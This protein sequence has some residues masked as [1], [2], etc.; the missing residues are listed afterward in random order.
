MTTHILCRRITNPTRQQ[1][2]SPCE[3]T[4]FTFNL[5]FL[6]LFIL[7]FE[8]NI[9]SLQIE[10]HNTARSSKHLNTYSASSLV[11]WQAFTWPCWFWRPYPPSKAGVLGWRRACCRIKWRAKSA[12]TS[13]KWTCWDASSWTMWNYTTAETPWCSK[14]LESLRKSIWCP[15]S[16]RKS[17]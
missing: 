14:P 4:F 6:N 11:C 13:W 16:R 10:T 5:L 3:K 7:N 8:F 12:S 9:V 15:S 2:I 1:R 17:A